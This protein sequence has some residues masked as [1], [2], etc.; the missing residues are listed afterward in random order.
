MTLSVP[1]SKRLHQQE[2]NHDVQIENIIYHR[3]PWLC[4]VSTP[5]T[6]IWPQFGGGEDKTHPRDS[7]EHSG[8]DN[9]SSQHCPHILVICNELQWID[10]DV[11]WRVYDVGVLLWCSRGV[12][13]FSRDM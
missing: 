11:Y 13:V 8:Q 7:D 4:H 12:A 5:S 10:N 9:G 2:N 3:E 1:V 6:H